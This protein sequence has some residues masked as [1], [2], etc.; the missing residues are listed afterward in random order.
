MTE[1]GSHYKGY[2]ISSSDIGKA[3]DLVLLSK[4]WGL[5]EF[6]IEVI[7][8]A[9]NAH[10]LSHLGYIESRDVGSP[11]DPFL[12]DMKRNLSLASWTIIKKTFR[13]GS[14]HKDQQEDIRDIVSACE[15]QIE[16]HKRYGDSVSSLEIIIGLCSA[17]LEQL[18]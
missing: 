15:R 3:I 14:A 1:I 17:E 2:V 5:G 8:L 4:A 16:L 18:Q 9:F 6:Q 7:A 12:I 11:L 13:L 10:G